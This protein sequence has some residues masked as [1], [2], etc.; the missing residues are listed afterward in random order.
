L[1]KKYPVI[2]F[3]HGESFEW[4]SGNS[5]DGSI[6][7]SYGQVIV[8]TL[9]YRLGALGEAALVVRFTFVFLTFA[10]FLGF[11][12]PTLNNQ[13]ANFGLLDIIAALQ[14][15][16]ENIQVFGGNPDMVTLLGYD[17]GAVCANFLMVSPVARGL[18]HRA[19]LM[20][21]SA[22]ADWALNNNPQ[23]TTLQVAKK[24]NCPIEDSQLG[25]CLR[26]KSY[27]EIINVTVSAP[28]FV[29]IYGPV[30]DGSV[31]PSD[32]YQGESI[33]FVLRLLQHFLF[34]H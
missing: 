6:L 17:T 1:A 26:K 21:G 30:V 10:C 9:N 3:L 11:M 7:A 18:F 31:V 8:I 2:V 23:D 4:N 24:L 32:P 25:D 16:K 28:E 13:V 27:Q 15:I 5:Y 22:L 20:S 29:T 19:I 14:W 33:A 12:K 34:I